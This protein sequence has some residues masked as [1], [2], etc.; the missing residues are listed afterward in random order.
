METLALIASMSM[1]I[2]WRERFLRFRLNDMDWRLFFVD[3]LMF[4]HV[5]TV[6][7]NCHTCWFS[8]VH[9]LGNEML[10]LTDIKGE[11]TWQMVTAICF[12]ALCSTVQNCVFGYVFLFA[13]V[14]FLFDFEVGSITYS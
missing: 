1:G 5:L 8:S 10:D 14:G 11:M 4:D 13:Y 2:V 3:P 12:L 6:L 7:R 9:V